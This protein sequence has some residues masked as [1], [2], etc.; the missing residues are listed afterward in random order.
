MYEIIFITGTFNNLNDEIIENLK[1]L[2]N[3]SSEIIIGIYDDKFTKIIEHTQNIK[4]LKER[5]TQ[6][7]KFTKKFFIINNFDFSST[8][9]EYI[10]NNYTDYDSIFIG[11]SPNPKKF[12]DT[13]MDPEQK[14]YFYDNKKFFY[15]LTDNTLIIMHYFRHIGWVNNLIAYKKNWCYVNLTNNNFFSGMNVINKIMPIKNISEL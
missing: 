7:S 9:K 3:K 14:I 4:S 13:E 11:P 6:L 12:I 2:K 15:Y 5:C 8:F 10:A 1:K